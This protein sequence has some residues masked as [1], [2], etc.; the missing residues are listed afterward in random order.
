M[1]ESPDTLPKGRARLAAVL[2]QAS[3]VIRIDDVAA[4]LQVDRTQAS[5]L[6]SRWV[7]QGWMRRVGPGT[8]VPVQLDLLDAGQVLSD[9][10]VLIPS[11]FSP[12]YVGGRTAAEHWD[13][14]EQIF[15]DVF[16]FSAKPLR[17]KTVEQQGAVF[18][19]KHTKEDLIFGIKSVWRDHTRVLVSDI[20]RTMVDMLDDPATGGGIQH[21]DDCF[22]QYVKRTDYDPERLLSYAARHGN[23]AIFKRL[24]FLA[25]RHG[26]DQLAAAASRNL[27]AGNAKLDPALACPR[28]VSRWHLRIPQS[29]MMEVN[30]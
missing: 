29:W 6:L 7:A 18:T 2:R 24:G 28:L 9:P 14:T 23:G 22:Q 21:V 27:T 11:L 30:P 16:V 5:K 26:I 4:A 20:H 13:L 3:D 8:Y 10:W 15:R 19:L 12:C 17:S 25:E 1:T